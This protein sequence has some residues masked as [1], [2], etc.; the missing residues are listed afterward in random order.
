RGTVRGLHYQRSPYSET[1]LVTCTEGAVWDVVVDIRE[2]SPTFLH[3]HAEELSESNGRALLI[4]AGF[5]HG[6]QTLSDNVTLIYCH[7]VPY[8]ASAES[9]LHPKDPMLN[10]PWPLTITAISSRDNHHP[11]LEPN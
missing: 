7:D 1:K 2:E 8:H 9:G 10:I 4:P 6:F 3:W 5:A 11:M